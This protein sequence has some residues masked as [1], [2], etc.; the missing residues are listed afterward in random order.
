[1]SQLATV[2][3]VDALTAEIRQMV[4]DGSLPPGAFLREAQ[5]ASSYSVAR[6]TVRAALQQLVTESLLRHSPNRGMHVPELDADDVVDIFR[7]RAALESEAVRLIIASTVDPAATRH[8]AE[9]LES[10][11]DAATW[12]RVVQA[13]L[14]FHRSVLQDAGS[15]RLIRAYASAQTEIQLCMVHLRP[16]YERPSQV[17]AEHRELLDTLLQGDLEASELAFR[18]HRDDAVANLL[19]TRSAAAEQAATKR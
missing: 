8:A 17:A 10:L 19:R 18:R 13:D 9:H 15:Q 5:L 2:S 3:T 4:L 12:D 14:A 6:H 1:M 7:L 16:N 11:D